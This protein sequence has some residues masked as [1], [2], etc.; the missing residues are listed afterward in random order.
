MSA[1]RLGFGLIASLSRPG[2]NITGSSFTVGTDTFGKAL[3]LLRDAVPNL[4]NVRRSS[5]TR[6][7]RATHS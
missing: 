4:R 1:T 3:E 6:P 7:I 5:R 2:G